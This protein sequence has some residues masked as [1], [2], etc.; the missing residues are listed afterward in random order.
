MRRLEKLP[1][2]HLPNRRAGQGQ[3]RRSGIRMLMEGGHAAVVIREEEPTRWTPTDRAIQERT[4][5]RRD[6]DTQ[7]PFNT[8]SS[9]GRQTDR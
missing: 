3:D 6:A 8:A 9:Y 1:G 2:F 4:M 5:A 7:R